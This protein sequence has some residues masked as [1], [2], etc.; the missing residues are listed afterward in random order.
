[1][2]EVMGWL[3]LVAISVI[4]SMGTVA[5]AFV[6]KLNNSN[7]NSIDMGTLILLCLA[8]CAWY[9]VCTNFPFVLKN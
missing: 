8:I 3:L 2:L 5:A 4:F 1:M 7:E 9:L 6:N